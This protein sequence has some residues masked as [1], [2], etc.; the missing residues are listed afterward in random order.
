MKDRPNL[1]QVDL[2]DGILVWVQTMEVS[3]PGTELAGADDVSRVRQALDSLKPA[4]QRVFESLQ[5]LNN[6]KSID[7]E[8][9]IG[10]SGKVGVFLAS[11]DT[12][13]TLKIKLRWEH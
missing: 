1:E 12:A 5:D 6:P 13:A 8:I 10:F 11:A 2:G 7:I 3:V 9:G 4:V